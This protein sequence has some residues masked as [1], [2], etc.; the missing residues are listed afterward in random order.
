MEE[1]AFNIVELFIIV[2]GALC[3]FN[4][5]LIGQRIKKSFDL[6]LTFA[7]D[8]NAGHTVD[9]NEL[10]REKAGVLLYKV[11]NIEEGV[12]FYLIKSVGEL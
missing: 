5:H 3:H 7:V 8:M 10:V 1:F 12:L 11:E 6:R 4:Y 2:L 9:K